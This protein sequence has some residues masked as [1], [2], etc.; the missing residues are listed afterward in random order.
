MSKGGRGSA[1]HGAAS[2]SSSQT[3]EELLAECVSRIQAQELEIANLKAAKS[4]SPADAFANHLRE[5]G[6]YKRDAW[7]ADLDNARAYFDEASADFKANP[8]AALAR[9]QKAFD[10]QCDI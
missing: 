9:L 10:E 3:T 5:E 1:T 7:K 2:S 6:A 8:D 4:S